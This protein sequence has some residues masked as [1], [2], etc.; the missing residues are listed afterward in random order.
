[1]KKNNLIVISI[2][3]LLFLWGI[4]AL[5]RGFPDTERFF[6]HYSDE[7]LVLTSIMK[8]GSPRGE[9]GTLNLAPTSI[10]HPPLYHYL[11][12]IPIGA[13]FVIGKLT[14]F[15][16]DKVDFVR[17]YFNNTQYFFLIGRI[18][19]YIFFWAAAIMIF[20]IAR[21]FYDKTV[22]HITT[23]AYL[24]V[25]KFIFDFST[26]RPDA[27]LFLMVSIFLYLFLRY[28][29][30]NKRIRYLYLSAFFVGVS[31]ATKYNALFLGFIF[32]PALLYQ[33]RH[34]NYKNILPLLSKIAFF[35]FLGFFIC[36]PFF[37]IRYKT[38][39]YNFFLFV[40][41]TVPDCYSGYARS[42]FLLTRIKD[43]SSTFYLNLFGLLILILGCRHFY[44][45][46]K[47]LAIYLFFVSLVFELYFSLYHKDCSPTYY[48]N[49]LLPIAALVFSAGVDFTLRFKRRLLPIS[50]MFFAILFLNHYW[51]LRDLTARPDYLQKARAFIEKNIPEFTNICIV[52]NRNLPQLNMTRE[53]YNHLI[54]AGAH[55]NHYKEMDNDEN[56]DSIFRE[57]RIQSLTKKPQYNLI[58]WDK[59]IKDEKDLVDFLKK[60]NIKYVISGG[61]SMINGKRL[62][63]T[64]SAFL[65]RTFESPNGKKYNRGGVYLYKI[66][67]K[68]LFY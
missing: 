65:M 61:V 23:F 37:I 31:T 48:L 34:R 51:V 53:S 33:M 55:E 35:I 18:M 22:A 3:I 36:N 45:R 47:E 6:S 5:T 15:F 1:M 21:L 9:A 66:H 52:S 40:T 41:V 16:S 8:F 30:D 20:K 59:K 17:F 12:F 44:K 58:K 7:R 32:I 42:L 10:L 19:S 64:K 46:N 49:P 56:Y 4:T 63:D 62:E 57:L 11:T 39:A 54:Q 38:Y 68:K 28:C 29:L 2:Y 27:L 50:I 24:L 26:T 67:E 13:F 25:P 14:G 60:N 43:I